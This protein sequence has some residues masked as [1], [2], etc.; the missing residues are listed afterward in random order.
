M[1]QRHSQP[2]LR[3][4]WWWWA[5]APTHR[6]ISSHTLKALSILECA[7]ASSCICAWKLQIF[8]MSAAYKT[9]F[10][11]A[12][13]YMSNGT[14]VPCDWLLLS[15]NIRILLL[16]INSN[17][18]RKLRTNGHSF[19]IGC[20]SSE[21]IWFAVI[22]IILAF[23][24][25]F[26]RLPPPF[27]PARH[28]TFC[29]FIVPSEW[30]FRI[31]EQQVRYRHSADCSSLEAADLMAVFIDNDTNSF[32]P[33]I[34]A[35]LPNTAEQYYDAIDMLVWWVLMVGAYLRYARADI[36]I[37][38]CRKTIFNVETELP[39]SSSSLL[40]SIFLLCPGLTH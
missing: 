32:A 15:M 31:I 16:H 26:R 1:K 6:K 21:F 38:E 13:M 2:E 19:Q 17:K 23:W 39:L 14:L 10:G 7:A 18:I 34:S 5:D 37:T 35:F 33:F 30:L 3:R 12:F 29:H 25:H 20:R 9:N 8:N 4:R 24:F 36:I 22:I 40:V 27:P 11:N 28:S